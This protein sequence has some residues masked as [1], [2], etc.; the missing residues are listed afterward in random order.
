[1]P[2]FPGWCEQGIRYSFYALAY[3]LP[4]SISL[5]EIFATLI[6]WGYLF[7]AGREYVRVLR[8]R[9][10]NSSGLPPGMYLPGVVPFPGRAFMY[11]CG[12][13]LAANVIST[14]TSQY[15]LKS[16]EALFFKLSEGLILLFAFCAT[17]ATPKRLKMVVAAFLLSATLT[18]LD[19]LYQSWSGRG[20]VRGFEIV[21]QARVT[22]SFKHPND[23]GGFLVVAS[24]IILSFILTGIFDLLLRRGPKGASSEHSLPQCIF[25]WA[26]LGCLFVTVLWS[27]GLTFSRGAWLG[28]I[29]ATLGLSF[30]RRKA[31]FLLLCVCVLFIVIFHPQ[32]YKV[33][34]KNLRV[35]NTKGIV[36]QPKDVKT[37]ISPADESSSSPAAL[38]VPA[39]GEE[40]ETTQCWLVFN[41]VMTAFEVIAGKSMGRY[42]FWK[43]ALLIIKDYPLFGAGLNTYS[44]VAPRYRINWGGYPHNCYLHMAA[45]TGLAGL[46]SFLWLLFVFL[47]RSWS[48]ILKVQDRFLLSLAMGGLTGLS[49]FLVQSFFDTNLYSVQLNTLFWFVMGMVI[50]SIRVGEAGR[51]PAC[52]LTN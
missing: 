14:V 30:F 33:R 25:V 19:A 39:H 34:G 6:I 44:E 2:K 36:M 4:I 37:I 10:G 28:F 13:F 11:A 5:V 21:E 32:L 27:L 29:V 42:N 9:K 41:K 49:G 23:F 17:M 35:Y 38:S 8:S 46:A 50:V 43:E 7:L 15:P 12:I 3:F 40:R 48:R 52:S 24:S 47:W 51:G 16:F 26:W 20:F 1:M 22:S 45:E 18:S 31:F